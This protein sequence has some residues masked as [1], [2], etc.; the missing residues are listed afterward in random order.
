MA[1][2]TWPFTVTV[3]ELSPIAS[4]TSTEA[5]PSAANLTVATT[6]PLSDTRAVA[7]AEP[8]NC[9]VTESE[10][11]VVPSVGDVMA[12]GADATG[13]AGLGGDEGG[14]WTTGGRL[15]VTFTGADTGPVPAGLVARAWMALAPSPSGTLT[16][17]NPSAP[18][19][20]VAETALFTNTSRVEAISA[21]PETSTESAVVT[22]PLKGDEMAGAG[23]GT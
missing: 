21:D 8:C 15:R 3:M 22:D 11:V 16:L 2:E 6:V 1:G 9:N 23:G 13:A 14:G 12:G 19:V 5:V 10:E 20:R 4:G 17:N 7:P 18:I